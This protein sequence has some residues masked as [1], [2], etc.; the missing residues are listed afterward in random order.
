MNLWSAN[1]NAG[2]ILTSTSLLL[3][4]LHHKHKALLLVD[5]YT[6]VSR[7]VVLCDWV[8]RAFTQVSAQ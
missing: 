6:P 7:R 8:W 2:K 3:L 1:E 4:L 5:F